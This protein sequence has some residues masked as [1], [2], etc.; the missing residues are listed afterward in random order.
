MEIHGREAL[1]QRRTELF[2]L[3]LYAQKKYR[4]TGREKYLSDMKDIQARIAK[5]EKAL[6]QLVPED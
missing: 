5:N 3:L 4:E 1:Y 6:R 2:E